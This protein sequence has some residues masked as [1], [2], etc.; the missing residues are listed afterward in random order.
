M[1][2]DVFI[3]WNVFGWKKIEMLNKKCRQFKRKSFTPFSEQSDHDARYDKIQV[4][5]KTTYMNENVEQT[6]ERHSFSSFRRHRRRRHQKFTLSRKEN[7]EKMVPYLFGKH[8]LLACN[9][10]VDAFF[11]SISSLPSL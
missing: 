2:N 9:M 8:F 3:C 11:L 1:V 5:S 6:N 7:G 10:F 4:T